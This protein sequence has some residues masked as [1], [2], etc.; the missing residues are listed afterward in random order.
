[1]AA[2]AS[3]VGARWDGVG[4]A[5]PLFRYLLEC[6]ARA[7]SKPT[8]GE[9]APVLRFVLILLCALISSRNLSSHPV[10]HVSITNCVDLKIGPV[11]SLQVASKNE[12][13]KLSLYI[14]YYI[15][16]VNKISFDK[17]K[18]NDLKHPL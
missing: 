10:R 3:G 11:F 8:P 13:S 2:G 17:N 16:Y 4:L 18:L 15:L 6:G 12:S 14:I 7:A 5:A 9:R 1:M